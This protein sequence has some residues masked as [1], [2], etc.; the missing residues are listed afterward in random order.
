[1]DNFNG[2]FKMNRRDFLKTTLAACAAPAIVRADSL[3]RIVPTETLVLPT[4]LTLP[5]PYVFYTGVQPAGTYMFSTYVKE[6]GSQCLIR[7]AK[8]IVHPGGLMEIT[9]DKVDNTTLLSSAQLKSSR[10][11][12]SVYSLSENWLRPS[13]T[14]N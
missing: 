3:M 9:L 12:E 10:G 8:K 6:A 14:S 7:R 1:V 2:E 4:A 11:Y 5:V 13:L